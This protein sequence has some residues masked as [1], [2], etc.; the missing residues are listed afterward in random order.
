MLD[1]ILDS[2]LFS[3]NGTHFAQMDG[4]CVSI[5]SSVTVYCLHC[6]SNNTYCHEQRDSNCS[7]VNNRQQEAAVQH[8]WARCTSD[9]DGSDGCV[10]NMDAF[11]NTSKDEN[12]DFARRRKWRMKL[13]ICN[14][15]FSSLSSV[16][17]NATEMFMTVVL[18]TS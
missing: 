18:L 7:F 3:F 6:L 4:C 9:D 13:C 15:L 8:Y 2:F 10:P 11:C 14:I 16:T 1:T 12:C 17:D 5:H